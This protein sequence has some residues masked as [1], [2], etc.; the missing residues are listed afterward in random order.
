MCSLPW[1]AWGN[2]GYFL[3][4]MVLVA[5]WVS[6]AVGIVEYYIAA[7]VYVGDIRRALAA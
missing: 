4:P 1:I 6:Y 7:F 5:G 2:L 3:A